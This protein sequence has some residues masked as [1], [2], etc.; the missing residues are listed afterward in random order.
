MIYS[1][2]RFALLLFMT[3]VH[4]Q[5]ASD[6]TRLPGVVESHGKVLNCTFVKFI[7]SFQEALIKIIVL[8]INWSAQDG[9]RSLN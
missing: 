6:C 7:N 4:S 2:L 3:R 5:Y 8:Q 1:V 9:N